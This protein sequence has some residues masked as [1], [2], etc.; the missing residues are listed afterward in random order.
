MGAVE[1]EV[2]K[3]GIGTGVTFDRDAVEA[4][5]LTFFGVARR[6]IVSADTCL[7]D[8]AFLGVVPAVGAD[9]ER[10]DPGGVLSAALFV[11]SDAAFRLAPPAPDPDREELL[12]IA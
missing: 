12:P 4:E 1:V 2:P 6:L 9:V 3:L 10:V 7:D 8:P 5:V 11:K